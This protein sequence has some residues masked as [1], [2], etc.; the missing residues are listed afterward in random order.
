MARNFK[1]CLFEAP[2]GSFSPVDAGI[3]RYGLEMGCLPVVQLCGGIILI[4]N[5]DRISDSCG[6]NFTSTRDFLDH[7][8]CRPLYSGESLRRD[9]RVLFRG[10][11]WPT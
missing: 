2:Q 10:S 7:R 4:L 9:G 3:F 6:R 8:P 5:L 11:S 1:A